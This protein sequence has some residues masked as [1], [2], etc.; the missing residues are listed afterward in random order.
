MLNDVIGSPTIFLLKLIFATVF[1][2]RCTNNENAL[3]TIGPLT[4]ALTK[5]I[6]ESADKLRF[7]II[8]LHRYNLLAKYRY[9]KC[10]RYVYFLDAMKQT[11]NYKTLFKQLRV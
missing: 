6:L 8:T 7:I 4:R 2:T 3:W 1:L 5:D 9:E 11:N 10:F